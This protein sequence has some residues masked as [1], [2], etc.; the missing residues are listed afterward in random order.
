MRK[1]FVQRSLEFDRKVSSG[2]IR[3]PK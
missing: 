2:T 3:R 1:T